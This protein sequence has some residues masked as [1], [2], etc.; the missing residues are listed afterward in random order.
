MGSWKGA[1][2]YSNW[3]C[4]QVLPP[5]VCRK[6]RVCNAYIPFLKCLQA[7]SWWNKT[8][9][10]NQKLSWKSLIILPVIPRCSDKMQNLTWLN[11]CLLVCG[12]QR[13][14]SERNAVGGNG[15]CYDRWTYINP[16]QTFFS[17]YIKRAL[18]FLPADGYWRALNSARI[19]GKTGFCKH[20]T[21]FRDT[22]WASFSTRVWYG[23]AAAGGRL[24]FQTTGWS[25][26]IGGEVHMKILRKRELL[27]DI[28]RALY[29][30]IANR[31]PQ[32][33]YVIPLGITLLNNKVY[34]GLQNLMQMHYQLFTLVK[35]S[36]RR[37]R[38]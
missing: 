14:S 6:Y 2:C 8:M 26:I 21:F 28:K 38:W 3:W 35:G 16:N 27:A 18:L 36:S 19:P 29:F 22:S 17:G 20:K 23:P 1:I 5:L 7:N 12:N 37:V 32:T 13:F 30:D 9:D 4:T 24:R 31:T 25:D 10:I 11:E 34:I 15:C 33:L